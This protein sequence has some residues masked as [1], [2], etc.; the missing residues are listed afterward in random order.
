M[1][2]QPLFTCI[3]GVE[4]LEIDN[5]ALEIYCKQ[6]NQ[7]R[8][9]PDNLSETCLLDVMAP[10]LKPLIDTATRCFNDLH[11]QLGFRKDSR[12]EIAN[13]SVNINNNHV[14]N[15]AHSHPGW[16]FSGVYYIRADDGSGNINFLSPNSNTSNSILPKM[17]ERPNSFTSS[18]GTHPAQVGKLLIF[19]SWMIHFVSSS[20][21]NSERISIAFNTRLIMPEGSMEGLR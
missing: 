7:N 19:P 6:Q 2:I 1:Q 15:S 21:E 10:E 13:V 3:L 11:Y 18:T 20:L 17:L 5:A 16:F 8:R 12:Q 4:F 14:I 9:D